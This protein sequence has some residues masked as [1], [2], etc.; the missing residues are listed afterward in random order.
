MKELFMV[1]DD[2]STRLDS[3]RWWGSRLNRQDLDNE[4]IK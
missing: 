2:D 1:D 3:E 4:K